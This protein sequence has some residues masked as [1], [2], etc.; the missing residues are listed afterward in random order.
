MAISPDYQFFLTFQEK[1]DT[2]KLQKISE[3]DMPGYLNSMYT[4]DNTML[5]DSVSYHA[6]NEA[7]IPYDCY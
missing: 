7:R 4:Q 3:P 2:E 6:E 5:I 1:M